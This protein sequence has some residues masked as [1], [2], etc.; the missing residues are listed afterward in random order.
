[1]KI[2]NYMKERLMNKRTEKINK[3]I[4]K[5]VVIKFDFKRTGPANK[6]HCVFKDNN[7]E[8]SFIKSV[9]V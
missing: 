5:E 2:F 3:L 6:K 4:W 8:L 7:A 1:M 9:L